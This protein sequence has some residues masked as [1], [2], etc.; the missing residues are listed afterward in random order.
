MTALRDSM[1]VDGSG[2]RVGSRGFSSSDGWVW[3]G[4]EVSEV[5]S[6]R[7]AMM[8]EFVGFISRFSDDLRKSLILIVT[9]IYHLST[10]SSN[11]NRP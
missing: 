11:H 4:F 2:S 1:N 8:M 3:V 9:G 5:Q 6:G 10:N 7:F